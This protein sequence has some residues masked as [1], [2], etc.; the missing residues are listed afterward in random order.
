MTCDRNTVRCHLGRR[1]KKREKE[2][3]CVVCPVFGCGGGRFLT[4]SHLRARLK[5]AVYASRFYHI[6]M[7]SSQALQ[8]RRALGT[9]AVSPH[10]T[11]TT[12]EGTGG[13][14][15]GVVLSTLTMAPIVLSQCRHIAQQTTGERGQGGIIINCNAS[16]AYDG[17]NTFR[18][19][20]ESELKQQTARRTR[21]HHGAQRL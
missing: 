5:A 8:D 10:R 18:R 16:S 19:P 3:E 12:G 1:E 21:V 13:G 7:F 15:G 17:P 4:P 11:A 20:S 9:F 6:H 14:R 2:R